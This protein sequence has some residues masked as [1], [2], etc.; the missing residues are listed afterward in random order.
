MEKK[1]KCC[2]IY[3]RVSTDDQH[4]QN[5]IDACIEYAKNHNFE[6]VHIYTDT[7]SGAKES[8]PALNDLMM[9]LRK[10]RFD[11]VLVWRL[12]RMGRSLQHLI[13]II[14][15]MEKHKVD[16]VTIDQ[17]IIDTTSSTGKLIF[18]IF[19]AIAEF[20]RELIKERVNLGLARAKKQGKQLGRPKGSKDKNPHGRKK[21]GY[22]LRY[23]QRPNNPPPQK[24]VLSKGEKK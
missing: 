8:R 11:I 13:Q 12:D 22:Y 19:G 20:E 21:S 10:H 2:G 5:Q 17:G 23:A 3:A 7:I 16:L 6:T 14:T 18:Q 9:D 15:E 1:T 24:V 4:P